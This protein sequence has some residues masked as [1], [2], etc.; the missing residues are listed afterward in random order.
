MNGPSN[1]RQVSV[2]H[3]AAGNLYGGIETLLVTMARRRASCPGLEPSFTVC[4]E[5]RLAEELRA[6]GVPVH[7]L[8]AA[9]ASRPWTILRARRAL[10]RV[11]RSAKFDAV[12][13]HGSWTHAFF[14]PV[15]RKAGTG[16]VAWIHNPPDGRHWLDRW[17]R[18]SPPDLVI[19]NSRFTQAA[20]PALFPDAAPE[21]ICCP[22]EPPAWGDRTVVRQK[23]RQELPTQED[24]VVIL[25][26]AR[27]EAWKGHRVLIEALGRLR[28]EPG[29]T[30]WIAGG[31]QRREEEEYLRDLEVRIAGRS[32]ASRVRMLGQRSDVP[33]LMAAADI[34]CQPN[35]EP[36][37]FGI[38]FIEALYAGL[39][40]IA[41]NTGGAAE[42][43]NADCGV[44]VPAGD[45]AAVAHALRNL[46]R[47]PALRRKLGAAGQSRAHALCEPAAR[48]QQFREALNR[49]R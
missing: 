39:P 47:E 49:P 27:M 44:L 48:L 30:C 14:A 45:A 31:A 40:V 32:L 46:I 20:V 16:L 11:L 18:T 17:A 22:I 42:I 5:G 12:V 13:S 34:Y 19:A 15:A 26:A 25:M 33:R 9:R 29:W 38:V 41:S 1:P 7:V 37:P 28:E 8:G 43:V 24:E 21:V 36:E 23:T 4:F 35:T 3:L 10:L 6:T 2:C